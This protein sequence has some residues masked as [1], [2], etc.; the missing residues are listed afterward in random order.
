MGE[1]VFRGRY[2]HVMDDKGR[3]SIPQRYREIL[4]ERQDTQLVI[5][6]LDSCLLAFPNSDWEKIEQHLSQV[7]F[8][9]KK[10]RGFL[11]F[12]VSGAIECQPDR[13][14]RLLIPTSLR[15]YAQLEKEV[16]LAGV[17]RCFE[18]WDR[19]AWDQVM[20]QVEEVDSDELRK[21]LGI[22]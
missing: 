14:G 16:V 3:I 4:T 21:E 17:L 19:K 1:E 9:R 6:T 22:L 12:F 7:S 5:T 11:R 8:L 15:E 10:L 20:A 2:F 18:I 13:Q